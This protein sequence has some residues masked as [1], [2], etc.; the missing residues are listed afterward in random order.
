MHRMDKKKIFI[1][2]SHE[3]EELAIPYAQLASIGREKYVFF[4]KVSLKPGDNWAEE[5]SKALD[6]CDMVMLLWCIHSSKSSYVKIE[7]ET[8]LK[9]GKQIAPVLLDYTPLTRKLKNSQW[10]DFRSITT[11]FKEERVMEYIH[12]GNIGGH[13]DHYLPKSLFANKIIDYL[14]LYYVSPEDNMLIDPS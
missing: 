9:K 1:S 13:I 2:Y 8:A 10:I 6:E 11:H 3:D 12:P 7:Y 4:D 14:N 5:I